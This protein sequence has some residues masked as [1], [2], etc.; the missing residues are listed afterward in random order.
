ME[1]EEGVSEPTLSFLAELSHF[2]TAHESRKQC[3][4]LSEL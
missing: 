3:E 4:G 1:K 2:N